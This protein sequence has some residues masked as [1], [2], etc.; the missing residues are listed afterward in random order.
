MHSPDHRHH[1]PTHHLM[2]ATFTASFT[3]RLETIMFQSVK[4]L[5]HIDNSGTPSWNALCFLVTICAK[6]VPA[7]YHPRCRVYP[8][9]PLGENTRRFSTTWNS[10]TPPKRGM[11]ERTCSDDTRCSHTLSAVGPKLVCGRMAS[12]LVK[13]HI[14]VD[15][16]ASAQRRYMARMHYHADAGWGRMARV[17][18][19]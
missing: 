10:A 6:G 12:R 7:T 2:I 4:T 5:F 8:G 19:G 17:S 9:S 1:L 11:S 18:H 13:E 14:A 15:L 16:L 3:T